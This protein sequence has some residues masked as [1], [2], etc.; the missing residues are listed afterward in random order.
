LRRSAL[1]KYKISRLTQR[2]RGHQYADCADR[3]GTDVKTEIDFLIMLLSS[4]WF[5]DHWGLIGL[6]ADP[7]KRRHI[8]LDCRKLIDQFLSGVPEGEDREYWLTD[9]SMER[10]SQTYDLFFLAVEESRVGVA[11]AATAK[12]LL[13][14]P[15]ASERDRSAAWF[16]GRLTQELVKRSASVDQEPLSP[17]IVQRVVEVWSG[18]KPAEVNLKRLEV[19]S[20]SDWDLQLRF[21][22]PDRSKYS[23][24]QERGILSSFATG[25]IKP[26][27]FVR[28]WDSVTRK[29]SSSERSTLADWY[30][31]TAVNRVPFKTPSWLK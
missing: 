2:F 31:S 19:A 29:L 18:L 13:T 27:A 11:F 23:P 6:D 3:P 10:H 16:L 15:V 4:D 28:F 7:A 9:F 30:I 26:T 25:I 12:L 1:A 21:V 20:D 5:F 17:E 22:L 14:G 8:Q 24:P